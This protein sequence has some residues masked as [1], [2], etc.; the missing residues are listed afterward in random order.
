MSILI[1]RSTRLIVQGITGRDGAFHTQQML[2]YGTRVVGG[3]TPGKG[4]EKVHGVPVFDS[5]AAAV[6]VTRANTSVIY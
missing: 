3:V 6:R 2:A 4:G 1:D 5:V